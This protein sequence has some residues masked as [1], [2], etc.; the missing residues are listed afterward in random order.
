[1]AQ[2]RNGYVAVR[3]ADYYTMSCSPES[4]MIDEWRRIYRLV[5]RHNGA[6]PDAGRHLLGW[7]HQAGIRSVRCS[8]S[9]GVYATTEEREDWGLSWADR[10]LT[11]GFSEQAIEYGY[12]SDQAE[13][14][15]ELA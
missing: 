15:A 6:E 8:A 11:T 12:A 9:V 13:A 5:A 3:D 7:F 4:E 14:L 1:M 10:C 2:L